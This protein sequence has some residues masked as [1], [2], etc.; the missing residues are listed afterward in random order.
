MCPCVYE[1]KIYV[2]GRQRERERERDVEGNVTP[3]YM[4]TSTHEVIP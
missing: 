4:T 1:R 2:R 3:D